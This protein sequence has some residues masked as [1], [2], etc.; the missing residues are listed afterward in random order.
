LIGGLPFSTELT[1]NNKTGSNEHEP[2][3]PFKIHTLGHNMTVFN[4]YN[5]AQ[6][7]H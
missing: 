6:T 3:L 1:G 7:I 2:I 5:G 4:F